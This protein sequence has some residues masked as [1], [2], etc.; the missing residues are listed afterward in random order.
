MQNIECQNGI[1]ST[2]WDLEKETL[3]RRLKIANPEFDSRLPTS[4]ANYP[5]GARIRDSKGRI[6]VK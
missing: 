2:G 5:I 3:A 1:K 4:N 6:E